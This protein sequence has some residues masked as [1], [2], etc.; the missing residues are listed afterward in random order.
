[1]PNETDDVRIAMALSSDLASTAA[2]AFPD[3][4]PVPPSGL[5]EDCLVELLG[6]RPSGT[7]EPEL[8]TTIISPRRRSGGRG[9]ARS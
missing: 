9:E 1:M 7:H 4:G 2:R 3:K 8:P 5:G 6:G